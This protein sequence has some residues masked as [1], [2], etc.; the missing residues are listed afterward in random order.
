ML[1]QIKTSCKI[2]DNEVW[3]DVP[4]FEGFYQVSNM[5]RIKTVEHTRYAGNNKFAKV[6]SM[7]RKLSNDKGGYQN[8]WLSKNG[9]IKLHKIHRLVAQVFIPNPKNKP[10][11]N[12][13]NG[14]KTDNRIENLEWCTCSE[15]AV[16]AFETGLR[17][18]NFL[19]R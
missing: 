11:V 2:N 4:S 1:N 18:S 14:I 12:H 9:K 16:H 8:V 6:S 15:N 3:K 19:K 17:T 7:I 5:G 13:I 10:Q